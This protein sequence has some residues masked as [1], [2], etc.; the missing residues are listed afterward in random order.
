MAVDG[1]GEG[2]KIQIEM[3]SLGEIGAVRCSRS[4]RPDVGCRGWHH[5]VGRHPFGLPSNDRD[6]PSRPSGRADNIVTPC[7]AGDAPANKKGKASGIESM[8]E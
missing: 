6:A 1:A 8:V 3:Q 4:A 2:Q 5:T 7:Q